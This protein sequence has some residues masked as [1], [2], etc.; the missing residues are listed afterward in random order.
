MQNRKNTFFQNLYHVHTRWK[1]R[2]EQN[3][4]INFPSY[5][6]VWS[7]GFTYLE[8]VLSPCPRIQHPLATPKTPFW[9]QYYI[10]HRIEC[11]KR[12]EP[13]RQ[14]PPSCKRC[15]IPIVIR[16][17]LRRVAA[18]CF[19]FKYWHTRP[20]AIAGLLCKELRVLCFSMVRMDP[21]LKFYLFV[22]RILPTQPR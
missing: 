15:A 7:S 4:K 14:L 21:M 11:R 2:I 1:A 3:I 20:Y 13:N 17:R 10:I 8:K 5:L 9:I 19:T 22:Y 18:R 12:P 16:R 6:L